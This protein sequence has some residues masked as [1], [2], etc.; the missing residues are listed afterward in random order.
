[1]SKPQ[2]DFNEHPNGEILLSEIR[3]LR[4][5]SVCLICINEALMI[6]VKT[7]NNVNFQPT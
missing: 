5:N 6:M 3:G 1:M 4:A 2:C 7:V